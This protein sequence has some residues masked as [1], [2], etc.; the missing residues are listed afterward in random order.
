RALEV[1]TQVE[2]DGDLTGLVPSEPAQAERLLERSSERHAACLASSRSSCAWVDD[3]VV[4]ALGR[5]SRGRDLHGEAPP[6]LG[7]EPGRVERWG[8]ARTLADGRPAAGAELRLHQRTFDST[9]TGM[10]RS[11]SICR[12]CS[13]ARPSVVR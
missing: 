8:A 7:T 9:P 3:A 11:S 1:V 13:G 6:A 12:S 10:R 4:A 2:L 5:D